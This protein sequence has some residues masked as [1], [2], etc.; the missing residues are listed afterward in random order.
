MFEKDPSTYSWLTYC[1]VLLLSIWG[2]A[3]HYLKKMR[4]G[5][6]R[7]S[8]RE[9][10]IDLVTSAFSGVITF[11]LFQAAGFNSLVTAAFV[12]VSGHMGSRAIQHLEDWLRSRL[13]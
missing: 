10:V 8:F 7:F 3:V 11:Y 2:G 4:T 5:T 1:W 9:L 6:R 12:G 13:P